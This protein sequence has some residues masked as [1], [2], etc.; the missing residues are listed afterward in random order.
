MIECYGVLGL[1]GSEADRTRKQIFEDG[2]AIFPRMWSKEEVS[3]AG[4]G[5]RVGGEQEK[6]LKLFLTDPVMDPVGVDSQRQW[7][8]APG[9][10]CTDAAT[11][12]EPFWHHS[13]QANFV[14]VPGFDHFNHPQIAYYMLRYDN[15]NL[16]NGVICTV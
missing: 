13:W 7:V 2:F 9:H 5:L 16:T 6:A 3:A 11:S 14:S 4:G 1:T 10:R 8:H 15:H 12:P